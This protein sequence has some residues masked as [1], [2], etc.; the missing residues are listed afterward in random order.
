MEVG[1][2]ST[3]IVKGL[4]LF[5]IEAEKSSVIRAGSG[6]LGIKNPFNIDEINLARLKTRAMLRDKKVVL[7][8]SE[9]GLDGYIGQSFPF[10]TLR[11]IHLQ[12]TGVD[13]F[14][15]GLTDETIDFYLSEKGLATLKQTTKYSLNKNSINGIN[16]IPSK[17]LVLDEVK[18]HFHIANIKFG[19]KGGMKEAIVAEIELA[20]LSKKIDRTSHT[21]IQNWNRSYDHVMENLTNTFDPEV[22][23]VFEFRLKGN[24]SLASKFTSKWVKDKISSEELGRTKRAQT[25]IGDGIGGRLTLESAT[26]EDSQQFYSTLLSAIQERKINVKEIHNYRAANG[27][28]YFTDQQVEELSRVIKTTTGKKP[29]ITIGTKAEKPSGYTAL[30]LNIMDE[31]GVPFEFQVRGK[32]VSEIAER[33][34]IFYDMRQGKASGPNLTDKQSDLFLSYIREC[35]HYA[36]KTELNQTASIPKFP[37]ELKQ[38]SNLS[39]DA[40]SAPVH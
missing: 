28:P 38:F 11:E 20:N 10:R 1:G 35:Y 9:S 34:H 40:P 8:H 4:D 3:E 6:S 19:A 26:T 16:D 17:L 13:L 18:N 31:S 29:E 30:H 25:F 22:F 21:L 12:R 33:E 27:I 24:E 7:D 36:R 39:M 32:S 23:G 5:N 14:K 2:G 15:T 37:K